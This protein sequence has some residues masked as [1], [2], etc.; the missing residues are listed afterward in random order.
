MLL[1]GRKGPGGGAAQHYAEL[2]TTALTPGRFQPRKM[3]TDESLSDLVLSIRQ[4]GVLQPLLVRA[5]SGSA[6]G[7]GLVAHEIVAGERRWRAAKLAGLTTVPVVVHK[8]DDKATL[9]VALIENLQ[10]EDLNPIE[11]AESLQ[12]L[13]TDFG[14]THQQAADA[15][16]R[17]RSSVSNSLRLLELRACARQFLIEGSLDMGHA[18]ALLALPENQQDALSRQIVA[19]GMSVREVERRIA[20][21]TTAA[22]PPEQKHEPVTDSQSRWLQYQLAREVGLN[23]G[24]RT[25]KG[26]NRRLGIEFSNLEQLETALTKAAEL[27]KQLRTTAGPRVR[28][29]TS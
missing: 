9:A 2:A 13:T 24:I 12:A 14:L 22:R 17:S 4:Q 26:G 21:K 23:V 20:K 7:S 16:G 28:E 15:V 27:V 29:S 6:A 18:R 3:I 10:R 19:E 5:I 8:L 1:G 25:G 11:I